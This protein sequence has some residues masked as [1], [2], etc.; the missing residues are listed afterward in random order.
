MHPKI[1]FV[2]GAP[3]E[4]DYHP[5]SACKERH[6]DKVFF[7]ECSTQPAYTY[8]DPIDDGITIR[9]PGLLFYPWYPTGHWDVV[10]RDTVCRVFPEEWKKGLETGEIGLLPLEEFQRIFPNHKEE[11][12]A[13]VSHS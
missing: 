3:M 2:C 10:T 8:Q 7:L 4:I 6:K 5:C 1:C 9:P 11:A 13:I 12:A